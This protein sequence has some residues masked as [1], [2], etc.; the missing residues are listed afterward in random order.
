MKRTDVAHPKVQMLSLYGPPCKQ[1]EPGCLVCE[2]W[3]LYH[4]HGDPR[5]VPLKEASEAVKVALNHP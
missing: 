3:R 4:N 5:F 1:Y 2:A